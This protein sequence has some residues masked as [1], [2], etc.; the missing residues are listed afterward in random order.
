MNVWQS[1]RPDWLCWYRA[2]EL[3]NRLNFV[4]V[5]VLLQLG[6]DLTV[7]SLLLSRFAADTLARMYVRLLCG[8]SLGCRNLCAGNFCLCCILF[9]C[10]Y[11][12]CFFVI[13][14]NFISFEPPPASVAC[15][16]LFH[17]HLCCVLVF[18]V[19]VVAVS[20]LF[21]FFFLVVVIIIHCAQN[22]RFRNLCAH[23]SDLFLVQTALSTVWAV[24]MLL[25]FY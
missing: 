5:Y 10:C 12:C 3:L 25:G 22:L 18:G 13:S 6:F 4:F 7:Q 19:A 14:F 9:F 1:G 21:F 8:S 11:C 17:C 2:L 16:P 23:F 24:S 20:W 15:P